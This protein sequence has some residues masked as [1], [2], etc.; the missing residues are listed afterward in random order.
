MFAFT[1]ESEKEIERI[2]ARYPMK[3][4]ALLPLLHLAQDQ[5]GYVTPEAMEE[6]AGR[7]DVSPAYVESVCTFYTMFHTRPVG[8]YVILFC[9]NISCKLL[10]A[11]D[12]LEYTAQKLGIEVGGTTTDKKFTLL[13]EECL[14][15]CCGA[16]MMR[17]NETFHE[18]LTKEKIDQIL[19]S[20][21]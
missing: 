6:I 10:G 18:F 15:A 21:P 16:P 17:V 11:D 3:R 2:L 5:E 12:L 1:Q 7:L 8:K 13:K 9:H 14:A 20:L 19:A 4:S